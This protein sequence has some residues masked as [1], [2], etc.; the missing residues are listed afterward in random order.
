MV[1]LSVISVYQSQDGG[2]NIYILLYYVLQQSVN[3]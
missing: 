2:Y 1:D 3:V